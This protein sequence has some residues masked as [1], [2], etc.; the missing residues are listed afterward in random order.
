MTKSI[1]VNAVE[2]ILVCISGSKMCVRP[3]VNVLRIEI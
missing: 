2:A 1:Y 3:T